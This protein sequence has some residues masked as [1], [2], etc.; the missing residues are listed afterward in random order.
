MLLGKVLFKYKWKERTVTKYCIKTCSKKEETES[1][2]II[3]RSTCEQPKFLACAQSQ[4]WDNSSA[5][6]LPCL[7]TTAFFSYI[8]HVCF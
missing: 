8:W 2:E 4:I 6:L 3:I 5:K 7:G 1:L